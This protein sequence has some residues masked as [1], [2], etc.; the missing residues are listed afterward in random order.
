MLSKIF[1][2]MINIEEIITKKLKEVDVVIGG[3]RD[4]DIQVKNK[5]FFRKVFL[6]ANMGLGESY[7]NKY[8][9]CRRLDQLIYRLRHYFPKKSIILK[10]IYDIIQ[11]KFINFQ[12]I[13]RATKV[14]KTHYD[15][16][17]KIFQKFL[18]KRMIY[19][20]GYWN[21]AKN[22]DEA[23]EKKLDLIAKKLEFKPNMKVLDVGCG[24]GGSAAYFAKKYRVQVVGITNSKEQYNYAQAHNSSEL[25]QFIYCDYREHKEKY[26]AI[27]SIGMFEN[28]GSKNYLTFFKCIKNNLKQN[29]SFLLHTIGMDMTVNT[30]FSWAVKYIFPNGELPSQKQITDNIEHNFIID[31]W[32]NFG[33]DYD[34]TLMQWYKN[35]VRTYPS[36]KSLLRRKVFSYV[37]FLFTRLNFL[38]CSNNHKYRSFFYPKIFEKFLPLDRNAFL[39]PL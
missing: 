14:A 24:W 10:N 9:E 22:L 26:D 34:K 39:L 17:V 20:C 32:H 36:F 23:Q 16:E 29:A 28:V 3:S 12:S 33:C 35:F 7:V 6:N 4:W 18:D 27:Y 15:L 31:D 38:R 19:T 30:R 1:L 5:K 21:N 13:K 25:T 2:K 37:E 8:F 11:D